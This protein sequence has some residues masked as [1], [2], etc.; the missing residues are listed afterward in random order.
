MKL[1]VVLNLN[2][3]AAFT[4]LCFFIFLF[5]YLK[6]NA[7]TIKGSVT[8]FNQKISGSIIFKT[9]SIAPVSEFVLAQNGLYNISLKKDYSTLFIECIVSGYSPITQHIINVK[10]DSTYL[11]NFTLVSDSLQ[12]LDAILLKSKTLP[13]YIKEDTVGYYVDKYKD[14]TERSLEDLIKKLPGLKVDKNGRISYKDKPIENITLDGDDLFGANYTTLT[15]NLDVDMVEAIEAIENYSE[16][17]LLKGLNDDSKVSLNLKLKA[18]KTAYTGTVELGAGYI[19]TNNFAR[20]FNTTVVG[21]NKTH[22]SFLTINSNNLGI[23][24]SPYDLNGNGS[25]E[26]QLRNQTLLAPPVIPINAAGLVLD[27]PTQENNQLFTSYNAAIPLTSRVK[28]RPRIHYVNSK[29]VLENLFTRSL[30]DTNGDNIITFDKTTQLNRPVQYGGEMIVDY[31]INRS[32]LLT[33]KSTLQKELINTE[34]DLTTNAGGFLSRLETTNYFLKQRLDYTKR[35]SKRSALSAAVFYSTNELPQELVLTPTTIDESNST[36]TQFSRFHKTVFNLKS[37]ILGTFKKGRYGISTGYLVESTPYTSMLTTDLGR[38]IISSNTLQRDI[39]SLYL[40]GELSY[41]LNSYNFTISTK[42]THLNQRIDN[43]LGQDDFILN[44]SIVISRNI[45]ANHSIALNAFINKTPINEI[46]IFP[47]AVLTSNRIIIKNTPSLDLQD[48]K[49]VNLNYQYRDL[50]KS[51]GFKT[52]FNYVIN[53]GDIFPS[54]TFNEE[55]IEFNNIFRSEKTE[56]LSA[57]F[58]VNKYFDFIST[59]FELNS[60]Y[61]QSKYKNQVNTEELRNNTSEN[62]NLILTAN[63]SFD[64]PFN[65]GFTTDFNFTE[66]STTGN[67][68]NFNTYK[69][70]VHIHYKLSKELILKSS[71]NFF[72]PNLANTSENFNFLDVEAFYRPKSSKIEYNIVL[73]NLLNTNIFTAV[74]QSDFEQTISS[75]QLLGRYSALAVSFSF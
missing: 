7:Q 52:A 63:T 46:N 60:I 30:I 20:A 27:R 36:S 39:Q 51:Q 72:I 43:D 31:Y 45:N 44:P 5:F 22:K 53:R 71:S 75:T 48:T 34:N 8:S 19:E 10:K 70:D 56:Q 67:S 12:Q 2:H 9:D 49:Q 41:R 32:S 47:N 33:Y 21:L 11:V 59:K 4:R 18:G 26:D 65:I 16:N 35:L 1:H 69:Q 57:S 50:F 58:G 25:S 62:F 55:N 15:K 29:T 6:S 3:K 17:P 66:F 37:Q 28:L 40:G 42:I 14:G 54:I 24:N 64:I 68:F 74:N 61:S 38:T 23:N 73:S 13:F